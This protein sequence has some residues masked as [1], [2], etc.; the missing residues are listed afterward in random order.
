M[1]ATQT[2]NGQRIQD[3]VIG[4][5][6]EKVIRRVEVAGP[7]RKAWNVQERIGR[8]VHVTGAATD[9]GLPGR[10]AQQLGRTERDIAQNHHEGLVTACGLRAE[11]LARALEGLLTE[12]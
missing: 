11:N 12:V 3:S 4:L 5:C 6:V 10:R 1:R 9:A 2:G 8:A 7:R